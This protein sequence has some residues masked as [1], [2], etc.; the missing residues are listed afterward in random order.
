VLWVLNQL[1]DTRVTD[2]ART[3]AGLEAIAAHPRCWLPRAEIQVRLERYRKG[4]K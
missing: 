4:G 3:I 2:A 1:F